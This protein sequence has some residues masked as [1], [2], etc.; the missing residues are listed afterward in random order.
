[1][2]DTIKSLLRSCNLELRR[3]DRPAGN[4]GVPSAFH[5]SMSALLS[6]VPKLRIVQVGANDGAI[7]DPLYGFVREKKARTSLILVEPQKQLLPYLKSN[8]SFHDGAEVFNGA[9]GPDSSLRLFCVREAFWDKLSVPYATGWPAYR[10]PTGVTSADRG[11]VRDWLAQYLGRGI[12]PDSAIEEFTVQALP[13]T[14][15]LERH[16]FPARIDVLQVDAEGFDDQVIYASDIARTWPRII[17]FEAM[18]IPESRYAALE[19]HLLDL[20]YELFRHHHD[21]LA[22]RTIL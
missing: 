22:V 2:K 19:A 8:Y 16:G 17:N 12:D 21:A 15:L 1:M 7:N 9:I 4:S 11:H 3:I 20:G 14:A 10:A 18:N 13:L 6:S 5:C